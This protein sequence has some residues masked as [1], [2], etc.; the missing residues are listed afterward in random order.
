MVTCLRT[1][2]L[3]VIMSRFIPVGQKRLTNICVVRYKRAGKRFEVA[4]YKNTVIAWRNKVET[5]I[6]EVLQ[7]HTIF[8]NVDK[9]ILAKREDLIDAFGTDDEDIVC[10]EVLNKGDFQ[11]SE[12]ERQMQTEAL[13]KDIASRVTAMCVNPQTQ[14]PYPLSTIERCMRET[15]HYAPTTT[16]SAKQQ[17]LQVV[18]QL[19]VSGAIPLMRAQMH[20]QML[21]SP[22]R[23]AQAKE[24][25]SALTA[26]SADRTHVRVCSEDTATEAIVDCI[27]EPG[28]FRSLSEVAETLGGSLQVVALRAD[29]QGEAHPNYVSADVQPINAEA[30]LEAVASNA[31]TVISSKQRAK[32]APIA[33]NTSTIAAAGIRPPVGGQGP[34]GG[35]GAA[36]G[37]CATA[38]SGPGASTKTGR[39]ER[40][41][42]LNLKQAELGDPVA[43]LEVGKAFLLGSGV[44]TDPAQARSWLE[45]AKQQGVMAAQAHLD[46]L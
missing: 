14:S 28:L 30:A 43:Q 32:A 25:I 45:Q 27:V 18:K 17:A 21:L 46:A 44:Q 3:S 24:Q 34:A 40:M 13:M 20:L 38:S 36:G 7:V 9:G 8:E 37:R 2:E 16:R 12:Q 39:A 35:R 5:D 6:D 33:P 4:A 11:V 1:H 31:S 10:V 42:K 22:A 15:I 29:A 19:Q 26:A 41:F 23:L